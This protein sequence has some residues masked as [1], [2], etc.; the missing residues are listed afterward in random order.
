VLGQ[1]TGLVSTFLTRG[2]VAVIGRFE[3]DTKSRAT[4]V[5]TGSPPT[6][7]IR[8]GGSAPV[9]RAARQS[10]MRLV[11]TPSRIV[12]PVA[13]IVASVGPT[14]RSSNARSTAPR[15][16]AE[17]IRAMTELELTR[18]SDD[19][20][21]YVLDG[22]GALRFEGFGSQRA[23]AEAGDERW[24]FSRRTF[25]RTIEAVDAGGATAGGFV[26]ALLRGGG[27]LRWRGRE[28]VLRTTGLTRLRYELVLAEQALAVVEPKGWGK[29]PVKL[30]VGDLDAVEP[31]LLLFAVFVA[32]LLAGDVAASAGA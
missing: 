16:P 30:L 22:V 18:S 10:A 27:A 13:L 5:G 26:S 6:C 7:A 29:R 3:P 32:H 19:K 2:A 1:S 20:R 11:G 4:S 25:R 15:S 28:Y 24:R 9:L 8:I 12:V 21:L 31:G 17:N 14:A 23:E